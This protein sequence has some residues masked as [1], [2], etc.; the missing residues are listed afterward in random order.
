M[1]TV[2]FLVTCLLPHPTTPRQLN[3]VITK[4]PEACWQLPDWIE[5]GCKLYYQNLNNGEFKICGYPN[6]GDKHCSQ[7]RLCAC[8]CRHLP[9]LCSYP[10]TCLHLLAPACTWPASSCTSPRTLPLT[11]PLGLPDPGPSQLQMRHFWEVTAAAI[12]AAAAAAA[13][14]APTSHAGSVAR[15]LE[16]STSSVRVSAGT[17]PAQ[18][19]SPSL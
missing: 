15:V 1:V 13:P 9:A 8:A 16:Q 5:G 6:P 17:V 11:E 4:P 12:V 7:V 18:L 19:L 3:Y 2:S 10:C 14:G